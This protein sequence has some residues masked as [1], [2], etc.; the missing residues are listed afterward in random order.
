VD[1]NGAIRRIARGNA[2]SDSCART[3]IVGAL[4]RSR[5][6]GGPALLAFNPEL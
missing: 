4:R 6:T 2:N 1:V 5:F 3:G